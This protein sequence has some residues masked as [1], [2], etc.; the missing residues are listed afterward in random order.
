MRRLALIFQVTLALI[1]WS[2]CV[3]CLANDAPAQTI[4]PARWS[5]SQDRAASVDFAVATQADTWL[6]HGVLGDPSFDSFKHRTTNP[7]VRGKAPFSWP[8]NGFLFEDPKSGYWYAYVGYY[9]TG[10]DIGP[11]LPLLHCRTH[12]SKDHGAT[13]EE[14]G[15][16]FTDKGF[17]FQGDALS[18]TAAPD[19][20]V[21]YA[22]GRYHLAYDWVSDNARWEDVLHPHD[23]FD[24]GCAY[25]WSER[26]EGPFHRALVPIIRSTEMPRRLA[27]G[28]KYRRAYGPSLIRRANDWLVLSLADSNEFFSWGIITQTAKDPNGAWSDPVLVMSPESNSYFPPTAESFPAMVHDGHIYASFTSVALNRN[29]QAVYRAPIEEGHRPEA[30]Q[31]FQHGTAWHSDPVPN[32]GMGIWGQTYSGFVDKQGQFQV[33]FPSR[34]RETN[35]GTI[36]L[37]SRPWNQPLRPRGFVLCGHAGSS[38]GLLRCAWKGFHLKADLTVQGGAARIVWGYQAPLGPDRHAS[39]ATIHPLSFTCHSGL[40]LTANAWRL[41]SVD[42]TGKVTVLTTGSLEEKSTRVIDLS[43]QENGQARLVVDR[44]LCWEGGLPVCSGS[45]G[46]LAD[47]FTHVAISRFEIEGASEPAVQAWLY[48]EALTGAG[49]N[50]KDWDVLHSPSYRFGVGATSKAPGA[51]AKWNFRGRGFRLWSPRGPEFGRCEL[52]L[53]GRKLGDLDLHA[54]QTCVSSLVY[55]CENAGDGYHAVVLHS[56][57][58]WLPVDSLDALQ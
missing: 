6:H 40:E 21:V 49:V 27:M 13:W 51:R 36:N 26:P 32:E 9:L 14:L 29:F 47:P 33:L 16:I 8:V 5:P 18:T 24:S 31:L 4:I 42:S 25:A 17:H 12:R 3:P 22:D 28:S 38:L 1:C 23:G 50:P 43:L 48:T 35:L 30:W 15:P 20:S 34:E 58:R 53:D 54:E 45:I 57:E 19:V 2:V 39:D 56:T 11:G 37:A 41:L 10:Y 46:L 44:R 52:L 7:I 55:A